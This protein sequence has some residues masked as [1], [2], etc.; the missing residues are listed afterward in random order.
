MTTPE[1]I[2]VEALT[3]IAEMEAG[4]TEGD[5][6]A[7]SYACPVCEDMIY[8]AKEALEKYRNALH[9]EEKPQTK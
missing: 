6:I 8:I 3:Q 7:T 5:L 9:G 4:Y 2:L 1:R